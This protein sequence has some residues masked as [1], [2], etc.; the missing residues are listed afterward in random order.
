[1]RV[2]TLSYSGDGNTTQKVTTWF[3][4]D[5]V[6]IKA[7]GAPTGTDNAVWATTSMPSG[8]CMEVNQASGLLTTHISSLDSDGFTVKNTASVNESGITY[9]A[10]CVQDDGAGDFATFTYEGDGSD[11]RDLST[12]C[13]FTPG[14]A[15]VQRSNGTNLA[16]HAFS[17]NAAGESLQFST[18]A[19]FTNRIQSLISGGIQVG[20]AGAVNANLVDF[21]GFAFKDTDGACKIGSYEGDG[22]DNRSITISGTAFTPDA[23]IVDRDDANRPVGRWGIAAGTDLSWTFQQDSAAAANI[24]QDVA[25]GSFE[26]GTDAGVNLATGTPTYHYIALTQNINNPELLQQKDTTANCST[27]AA[28]CSGRSVTGGTAVSRDAEDGATAGSSEATITLSGG[29]TTVV[30]MQLVSDALGVTLWEGGNYTV[31]VNVTTSD[32]NITLEEVH[33]CRVNSSCTNQEDLGGSTGLAIDCGTT[34]VKTITVEGALTSTASA[35][36]HLAVVL[37]FTNSFSMSSKSIGITP[38]QIIDT[39]I[40]QAAAAPGGGGARLLSLLGVG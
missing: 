18:N 9:V 15:L 34:G 14:Y 7:Q 25:S 30:G 8:N 17:T 12:L 39:P 31:R 40:E 26:V 6:F 32:M 5:L 4:P 27:V 3:A 19:A 11:N 13:S 22:T 23:I 36:D 33:L 10:L 35:T 2:Q 37:V 38:N 1:M 24:I 21:Y 16:Q 20:N 28:F 29:E